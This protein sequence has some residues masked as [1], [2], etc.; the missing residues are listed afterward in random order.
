MNV[1]LAANNNKSSINV[2][3]K[4]RIEEKCTTNTNTAVTTLTLHPNNEQNPNLQS[5]PPQPQSIST[6]SSFSSSSTTS[7]SSSSIT[8]TI[9]QNT[10]AIKLEDIVNEAEQHKQQQHVAYFNAI[11][12]QSTSNDRF[13]GN[14]VTVVK[15][16]AIELNSCS[17]KEEKKKKLKSILRKVDHLFYTILID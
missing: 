10:A 17:E 15:Q 11:S 1:K 5:K 8:P 3:S 16:T 2:A 9:I 14:C 6:S 13:E 7:S 4:I 12:N